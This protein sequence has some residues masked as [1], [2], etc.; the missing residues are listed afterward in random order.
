[1]PAAEPAAERASGD[2]GSIWE[3]SLPDIQSDTIVRLGPAM[4]ILCTLILAIQKTR[5]T[6]PTIFQTETKGQK[7]FKCLGGLCSEQSPMGEMRCYTDTQLR[8]NPPKNTSNKKAHP[9]VTT[10]FRVARPIQGLWE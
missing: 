8:Q 3:G 4:M 7:H 2:P 5:S 1:M 10:G 6:E 9:G